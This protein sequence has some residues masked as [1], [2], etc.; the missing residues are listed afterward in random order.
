MKK[1]TIKILL[2]FAVSSLF[3]SCG[4]HDCKCYDTNVLMVGDSIMKNDLDTVYSQTRGT[5]DEFNKTEVLHMDS[6]IVVHH[7]IICEE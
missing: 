5:C 3:F 1:I 6:N 7:N 2:L 4:M